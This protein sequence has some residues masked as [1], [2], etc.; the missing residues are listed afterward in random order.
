MVSWHSVDTWQQ[1]KQTTNHI[2]TKW[3]NQNQTTT[4]QRKKLNSGELQLLTD[5]KIPKDKS[6]T[7]ES[8]MGQLFGIGGNCNNIYNF[9]SNSNEENCEMQY[10]SISEQDKQ[11]M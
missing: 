2:K 8:S 9:E 4:N 10:F 6:I 7:F 3:Q 5:D 11:G 1:S